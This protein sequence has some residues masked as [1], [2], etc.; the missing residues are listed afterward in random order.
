M[1][2]LETRIRE[3]LQD[4]QT[5][6]TAATGVPAEYAVMDP[7]GQVNSESESPSPV[8]SEPAYPHAPE[9]AGQRELNEPIPENSETFPMRENT[10]RFSG[11]VWFEK[12]QEKTVTLA[13]LGGIGGYVAFLLSRLQLRRII[14]Y[15]D[16]VVE[17]ANLSGQMFCSFDIGKSKV[18]AMVDMMHRYS[19]FYNI[20]GFAE[21]FDLD[22][23]PTDI[24]ICGFD[25]MEARKVFFEVWSNWVR[26][27]PEGERKHCLF[28]DG[29]LA[30]ET[31]QVLC[32][33]GDDVYNMSRYENEWLF[34]DSQAEPTQCSY[35]Q[36]SFMANMIGSVIVNLFVNFCANDIEGENAPAI[37]RDLPF[38]TTYDASMMMFTTEN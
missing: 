5:Q 6:I 31:L 37:E 28:I 15:D 17:E 27:L 4:L 38:L 24:M 11:A 26:R 36:T 12:V 30:A 25:N 23:D 32:I 9:E 33:R 2:S 13:G 34:S 19:G 3:V 8:P 10:S 20:V 7:T 21:R 35:K 1:E 22:G 14:M 29:R 18:S 16:D